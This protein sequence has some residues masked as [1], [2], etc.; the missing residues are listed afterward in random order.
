MPSRCVA[1]QAR[2][3]AAW[4][5]AA[6]EQPAL[7]SG[8]RT[9]LSGLAIAAVS[10]MSRRAVVVTVEAPIEC[11]SHCYGANGWGADWVT[12]RSVAGGG[13]L[14]ARGAVATRQDEG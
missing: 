14:P 5:V 10:A 1:R 3:S 8:I 7:G 12:P 11:N 2:T 13:S 6:S 4:I 9:R